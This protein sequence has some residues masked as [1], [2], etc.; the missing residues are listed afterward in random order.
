MLASFWADFY[1]FIF[2]F[3]III[4]FGTRFENLVAKTTKT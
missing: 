4:F 1:F 3:I 2:Y